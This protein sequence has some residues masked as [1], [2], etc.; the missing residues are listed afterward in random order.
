M[1]AK[2]KKGDDNIKEKPKGAARKR[3]YSKNG[4]EKNRE[5]AQVQYNWVKIFQ[6]N[7]LPE[8]QKNHHD[9]NR[10]QKGAHETEKQECR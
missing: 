6:N 4:T 9:N 7:K 8:T 10:N 2:K 1:G 5:V 3:I